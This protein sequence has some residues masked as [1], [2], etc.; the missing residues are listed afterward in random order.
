MDGLGGQYEE[1]RGGR[2]EDFIEKLRIIRDT[3]NFGINVVVRQETIAELPK[4]LEFA[5]EH[6][7]RQ[8]LFLPVSKSSGEVFLDTESLKS[9]QEWLKAN[10]KHFPLAISVNASRE[11][12]VPMLPISDSAQSL[13]EHLH[14]DAS[15]SLKET[16]FSPLGVRLET[17]ELVEA[18]KLIRKE[19]YSEDLVWIRN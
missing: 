13:G 2:F 4:I 6:G 5:V 18:I 16:A 8:L 10:R 15:G 11:I 14:I 7:A 19:K 12:D 9:L 17:S 3:S 1:V